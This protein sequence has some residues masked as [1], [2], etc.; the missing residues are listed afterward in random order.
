MATG[1]ED[2]IPAKTAST[3]Y[4][5]LIPKQSST[6]SQDDIVASMMER[7]RR[8]VIDPLSGFVRGTASVGA[9]LLR[10]FE[11]EKENVS[12]RAA[13]DEMLKQYF[14][15]QPTSGFYEAGKLA[16]EVG[17]T[18]GIGPLLGRA[19]EFAPAVSQAFRT[20]GLGPQ[21]AGIPTRVGAGALAGGL[22][23][24]AVNPMD[25]EVGALIG[26]FLPI[27]VP[28]AQS[29]GGTVM[30][31]TE[32]MRRP[33]DAAANQLLAALGGKG[34]EAI[35]A[36]VRSRGVAV[37]PGFQ[38]TLTERLA[39]GDLNAPTVAAME[40]RLAR[41]SPEINQEIFQIQ[42]Q[43]I[44]ALQGQLDRIN[45]QINTQSN[46][47]TP[48]S[49]Q[50]LENMRNSLIQNLENEQ[51]LNT[52]TQKFLEASGRAVAKKLP[53]TGQLAPGQ[54]L[55]DSALRLENEMRRTVVRPAYTAAI[56]AAGN[57]RIDVGNLIAEAEKILG[58]PLSK[59]APETS[60]DAVRSLLQMRP[61]K[62]SDKE[63]RR[64]KRTGQPAPSEESTA[65]LADLDALRKSINA[66]VA[67]ANRGQGQLDPSTAAN[68]MRLHAEIDKTIAGS[69]SLSSEAKDLYQAALKT[70]RDQYAPRFKTG[71]TARLL[72]PTVFGEMRIMPEDAVTKFLSDETA[73]NQFVTT[74]GKDPKA[75]AAMST[76]VV[77]FFRSK[78]V[79]PVTKMVKPEAA[80]KF[81]SD[82]GRQLRSL[83]RAGVNVRGLLDQ[84]L[85][86]AV[87]IKQGLDNIGKAGQSFNRGSP[88]E[89]I[90]YMLANTSNMRSGLKLL[91]ANGKQT[92]TREVSDRANQFIKAG[93]PDKALTFLRNNNETLKLAMGDKQY[94]DLLNMANL[95]RETKVVSESMPKITGARIPS[96]VQNLSG[97]EL[98][99]LETV[100]RDI[101]RMRDVEGMAKFGSKSA[102]PLVSDIAGEEAGAGVVQPQKI[103]T[104][105]RLFSFV[106][107]VYMGVRERVNQKAAAELTVLMYK[108]P[109]AA[110]KAL[111]D[112]ML[113]KQAGTKP[114]STAGRAAAQALIL[115][116]VSSNALAPEPGNALAP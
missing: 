13:V 7:R 35:N 53:E 50:E 58:R 112:A 101:K 5:D 1:Y 94:S 95:M 2:L 14:G 92:L 66:D 44:G 113:R 75:A 85:D 11:S 16:G 64:L 83:E 98:T 90:D 49:R 52:Q 114:I 4:E 24:G 74:F 77:D 47:L 54:D 67:R 23:A 82:Y 100:A 108:D 60:P 6:P 25:A 93:D 34:D 10:P 72:K 38:P 103:Q 31:L 70:Y 9:T 86:E 106:R 46:L 51:A 102:K 65:S 80:A 59:F 99:A 29:V 71:E 45:R 84:T 37:T 116:P 48:A 33:A 111:Q 79:D 62:L 21:A 110:I 17:A 105:N 56:E 43:R 36:L 20:G 8:S 39:M 55:F 28:V 3:G 91:D 18:L 109:D 69:A 57:A 27:G 32:P 61:E 104:L 19:T 68:L 42:Q 15:A 73:A 63:L 81:L 40:S 87:Q 96:I 97:N 30:R 115:S 26:G 41:V 12:R 22:S 76:G 107:N 89:M 88:T 78:V